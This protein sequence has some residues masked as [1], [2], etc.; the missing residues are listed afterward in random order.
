MKSN[1]NEPQVLP[2]S[3][4]NVSSHKEQNVVDSGEKSVKKGY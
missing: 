2:E 4:Q 1:K 3:D